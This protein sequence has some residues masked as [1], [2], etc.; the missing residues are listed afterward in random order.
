MI[1]DVSA[2]PHP[3]QIA[4]RARIGRV[5]R[6]PSTGR[7]EVPFSARFHSARS[8]RNPDG[9]LVE[10]LRMGQPAAEFL[11]RPSDR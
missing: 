10:G 2:S 4:Y 11:G 5:M 6:S 9:R 7:V 3:H 1:V 8:G